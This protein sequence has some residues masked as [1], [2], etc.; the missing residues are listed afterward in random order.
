ML[1]LRLP[2]V[3][4]FVVNTPLLLPPT[5]G[6]SSR[7]RSPLSTSPPYTAPVQLLPQQ[8]QK[9]QSVYPVEASCS[10]RSDR[11]AVGQGRGGGGGV[12]A[13]ASSMNGAADVSEDVGSSRVNGAEVPQLL[14][15]IPV[16]GRDRVRDNRNISK[17]V[18]R[19]L[20]CGG[21][22]FCTH[23]DSSLHDGCTNSRCHLNLL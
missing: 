5:S 12:A 14:D 19:A 2:G 11:R 8:Q 20:V 7:R 16:V 4:A 18:W 10:A 9:Q 21:V 3:E 15:R 17:V 1:L 22:C 23:S 6:R 13:A